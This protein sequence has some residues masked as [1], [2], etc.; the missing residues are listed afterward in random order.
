M[1]AGTSRSTAE[2]PAVRTTALRSPPDVIAVD[3]PCGTAVYERTAAGGEVH[4]S[5]RPVEPIRVDAD[6][7]GER[8]AERDDCQPAG[9][10]QQQGE[11]RDRNEGQ[12]DDARDRR[13]LLKRSSV[14]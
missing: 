1:I 12:P 14:T 13:Q 5:E 7:H 3:E 6:R 11:K 8:Q 9:S 4:S 2:A 10:P